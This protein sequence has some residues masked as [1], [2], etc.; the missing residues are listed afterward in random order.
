MKSYISASMY[1]VTLGVVPCPF[2]TIQAIP[3]KKFR[4]E[5]R[6]PSDLRERERE[7]ERVCVSVI[8]ML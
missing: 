6:R 1:L 4:N 5:K 7:R 8:R 2:L 3:T